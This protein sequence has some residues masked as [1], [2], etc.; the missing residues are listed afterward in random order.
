MEGM[1]QDG[2]SRPGSYPFPDLAIIIVPPVPN[3]YGSGF[4]DKIFPGE[5]F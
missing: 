5:K 3:R 1:N 2:F 4:I